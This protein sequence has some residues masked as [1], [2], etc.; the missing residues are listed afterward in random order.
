MKVVK[1]TSK[2][3]VT[4]PIEIRV[5]L[6]IDEESYLEVTEQGSEIRLRKIVAAPPLTDLDP[7]WSLI[8]VGESAHDDVAEEHDRHLAEGE[9]ER[10]RGSS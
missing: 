7:I 3:Q 9:T 4:I 5:A 2:G 10:W 1:V 6:G 8:G